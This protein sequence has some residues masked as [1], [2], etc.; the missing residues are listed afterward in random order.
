ML[1]IQVL[2]FAYDKATDLEDADLVFTHHQSG[3]QATTIRII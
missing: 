3:V 2:G 1:D